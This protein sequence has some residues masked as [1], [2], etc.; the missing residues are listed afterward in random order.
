MNTQK[1][2]T[3]ELYGSG[4]RYAYWIADG[5]KLSED[6]EGIL[7]MDRDNEAVPLEFL[8]NEFN[9]SY[10]E[11]FWNILKDN[12]LSLWFDHTRKVWMCK[13]GSMYADGSTPMES[14]LRV[15]VMLNVGLEIDV[16]VDLL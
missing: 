1:I 6:D 8:V 2:K 9:S 4:L 10:W 12:K 11:Y 7:W 13:N 15:Y 14:V 5:Y 16:P 3:Y